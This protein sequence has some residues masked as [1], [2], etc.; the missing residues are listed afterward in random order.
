MTVQNVELHENFDVVVVL[1]EK[2]LRY[3]LV[4]SFPSNL[5]SC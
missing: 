1:L 5:I 3:G 4:C 2:M